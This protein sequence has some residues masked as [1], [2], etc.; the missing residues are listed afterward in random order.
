MTQSNEAAPAGHRPGKDNGPGTGTHNAGEDCGICH[1]P[2]GKAGN[3]L[4]TLGGTVY[5]D[6]AARRHV[7]MLQ[8]AAIIHRLDWRGPC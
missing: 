1:T 4:F 3:F 5:E 6:R 2:G 8:A 7:S